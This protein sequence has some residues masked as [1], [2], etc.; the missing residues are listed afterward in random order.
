MKPAL[1]WTDLTVSPLP[2]LIASPASVLLLIDP[3][4]ANADA[5]AASLIRAIQCTGANAKPCGSCQHCQLMKAHPDD[6]NLINHPDIIYRSAPLSTKEVRELTAHSWMTPSVSR[7]R[8]IY[9]GSIDRYHNAAANALLKTLEEPPEYN[10]FILSAPA[11]RAVKPTILSRAQI[12][13]APQPSPAQ[14]QTY[15][16]NLGWQPEQARALL[17]IFHHNPHQAIQWH[18]LP[19]PLDLLQDL[20]LFAAAPRR[21]VAFLE[22]LDSC[23]P[24]NPQNKQQTLDLLLLNLEALIR[25]IQLDS[26]AQN[27]HNSQLSTELK[28]AQDPIKLHN[29]HAALCALRRPDRQQIGMAANLKSLL[30]THLDTRNPTL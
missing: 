6:P 4:R 2:Q 5:L 16:E 14:A 23:I 21:H 20:A 25:A 8:T 26:G 22:R 7:R 1:P 17:P 30:L 11:R 9:L 18:Q 28:A 24:Y 15:L 10:S 13:T 3:Q 12:Y 27:W 19:Y 29:L